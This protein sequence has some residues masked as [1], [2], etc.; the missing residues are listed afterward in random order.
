MRWLTVVG[1]ARFD[2]IVRADRDI[3]FLIFV[4]IEVADQNDVLPVLLRT[5]ALESGKDRF[6]CRAERRE[7][8]WRR[9]RQLA[10]RR[11]LLRPG[12]DKSSDTQHS[13]ECRDRGPIERH[14]NES[15]E[16][17]EKAPPTS[18]SGA[19]GLTLRPT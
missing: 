13:R 15:P 1:T 5:P 11:L 7:L 19:S 17:S 18:A 6:T 9:R 12:G 3:E 4:A 14:E 2:A 16:D 8:Q 10:L